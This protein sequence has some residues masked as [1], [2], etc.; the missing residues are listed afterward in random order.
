MGDDIRPKTAGSAPGVTGSGYEG[1]A[2]S[3]AMNSSYQA[4][5]YREGAYD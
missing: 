1:A 2:T 3:H 5:R 4:D